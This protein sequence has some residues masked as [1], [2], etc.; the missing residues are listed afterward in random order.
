MGEKAGADTFEFSTEY[1]TP[2]FHSILNVRLGVQRCSVVCVSIARKSAFWGSTVGKAVNL[3]LRVA[4]SDEPAPE[5]FHL[6][7]DIY[8]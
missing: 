5:D 8:L 7:R 4:S 2:R 3:L 6:V 1:I